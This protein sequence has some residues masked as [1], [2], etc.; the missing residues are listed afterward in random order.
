VQTVSS[1]SHQTG[2]CGRTDAGILVLT[3]TGRSDSRNLQTQRSLWC[4]TRCRIF[5]CSR[6]RGLCVCG[7]SEAMGLLM[8]STDCPTSMS[9]LVGHTR[10]S[11]RYVYYGGY[12]NESCLALY[13]ALDWGHLSEDL[14]ACRR[15]IDSELPYLCGCPN[16]AVPL[17]YGDCCLCRDGEALLDDAMIVTESD[18]KCSAFQ[19]QF[20]FFCCLDSPPSGCQLCVSGAEPMR[21]YLKDAISIGGSGN[22]PGDSTYYYS[23]R[24]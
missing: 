21:S 24:E 1:G 22:Y 3:G 2:C 5:V 15:A 12:K 19:E 11:N 7:N 9:T 18:S 4:V 13:F 10:Y 14:D 17:G 16:E 6:R 20:Q 23:C 8:L